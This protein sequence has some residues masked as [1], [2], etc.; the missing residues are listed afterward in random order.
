MNQANKNINNQSQQ[1]FQFC[2]N[3]INQLKIQNFNNY[4]EGND[5]LKEKDKQIEHLQEQCYQLKKIIEQQK[6]QQHE[7]NKL[8]NIK[9]NVNGNNTSTNFPTK[10]EIKK[11]WEDMALSSIL[12]N[13]IDFENEPKQIYH[14]INEMI[15]KLEKL[16]NN[17]CYK[18]YEKVSLSL[19]IPTN[20]KKFMGDIEKTARPLIKEHLDKIFVC[21]ENKD[22][23]KEFNSSFINF[24]NNY[25][26]SNSNVTIKQ[27]EDILNSEDFKLL[28]K[29]MKDIILFN[30]FNDPQLSFNIEEKFSKRMP[31]FINLKDN[32]DHK[33]YLIINDKNKSNIQGIIILKPPVLRSGFPLSSDFKSIIMID[34]NEKE[35]IQEIQNSNKPEL[36]NLFSLNTCDKK[37]QQQIRPCK[38][39]DIK[40]LFENSKNKVIKSLIKNKKFNT[41]RQ[42][43]K[44][45]IT[46]N[47]NKHKSLKS[48]NDIMSQNNQ[49]KVNQKQLY[50]KKTGHNI[51]IS[52]DLLFHNLNLTNMNNL[53]HNSNLSN[54]HFN[55]FSYSNNI[56]NEK[57]GLI[58]NQEK[59]QEYFNTEENTNNK[60][61]IGFRD[62]ISFKL[63]NKYGSSNKEFVNTFSKK[64]QKNCY[65]SNND[66]RN[67]A[68]NINN[69]DINNNHK[70][71]IKE[72]SDNKLNKENYFGDIP[73]A[74]KKK[75]YDSKIYKKNNTSDNIYTSAPNKKIRSNNKTLINN[76]VNFI[77][78]LTQLNSNTTPT[79]TN[80]KNKNFSNIDVNQVSVIKYKEY[81]KNQKKLN[82]NINNTNKIIYIDQAPNTLFNTGFKQKKTVNINY[83]KLLQSNQ[84]FRERRSNPPLNNNKL[85]EKLKKNLD[86]IND[87]KFKKYIESDFAHP[88][89][90]Y[91][92]NCHNLSDNLNNYNILNF[93][94]NEKNKNNANQLINKKSPNNIILNSEN[95]SNKYISKNSTYIISDCSTNSKIYEKQNKIMDNKELSSK[96]FQKVKKHRGCPSYQFKKENIEK[97]MDTNNKNDKENNRLQENNCAPFSYIKLVN[98]IG[99]IKR[100]SS[101]GIKSF[102]KNKKILY[103]TFSCKDRISTSSNIKF[104]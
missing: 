19:N 104:D 48:N 38:I 39:Q 45:N 12:D 36:S 35:N 50:T 68:T 76:N 70:I 87:D 23:I 102:N 97:N 100:P 3:Q 74:L 17:F 43:K 20:N 54:E 40:K 18:L 64:F 73:L 31:E 59:C 10:N 56:I 67:T 66:Q 81:S 47:L 41:Q 34:E 53:N 8:V 27:F 58:L 33:K 92:I 80:F 11:I 51:Q 94:I 82:L 7:N 28:I 26:L 14:L 16:I 71:M 57:K 49:K 25:L 22:F 1:L 63:N 62:N 88:N 4:T 29:K 21:T 52:N 61:I 65:I 37:T 75:V 2:N 95:Q 77:N 15:F 69:F 90:G 44:I 85:N 72:L 101:G 30:I 55:D 42:I 93:K 24:Y 5:L 13:F 46:K 96:T 79:S 78:D 99:S 6:K 84:L 86:Q 9:D 91:K 83:F 60:K 98:K 89:N 103:Q 32:I